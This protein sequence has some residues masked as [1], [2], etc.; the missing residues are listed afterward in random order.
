LRFG[1][2]ILEA[3]KCA[4][5]PGFP[6][7]CR[8]SGEE[9]VHD[10]LSLSDTQ[11]IAMALEKAGADALH[12]GGGSACDS[13]AWYFQH[14]SLPERAFLAD[15]MAIKMTVS[16]PVIAV[17]RLGTPEKVKEALNAFGLDFVAL[18]RPLIADPDFPMK[19]QSGNS[20]DICRCGAC[21]QGCL[22]MVKAGKGLSCLIN[23]TVGREG[24]IDAR[25]AT[26]PKTVTVI[27]GGPAGL[28]AAI[29][30]SSRGHHVDLYERDALGGQ[31]RLA[32]QAPHKEG[33]RIPY[34]HLLT[35]IR[36]QK[37]HIYLGRD[38][39]AA[40]VLEQHPDVVIVSTGAEP[41]IPAIHGLERIAYT[42]GH[43]VLAEQKGVGQR[44]LII[45]GGMV[46]METAEFLAQRGSEITVIE[47][48]DEIGRDMDTI[49]RALL[50]HRIQELPIKVLTNTVVI[51]FEV[52]EVIIE[53]YGRRDTLAAFDKVVFAVGTRSVDELSEPLKQSGLKVYT[54][55]DALRPRNALEAI[56]EGFE[57]GL[58]I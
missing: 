39:K 22:T 3:V 20:H 37:V 36:K 54:I 7:I 4:A 17:G 38:L 10:G 11:R 5:G 34:Q 24:E 55:G 53:T 44:V 29:I 31:F 32:C 42:T 15:A 26:K 43:K 18:G 56:H 14:S 50:L 52:R 23:P 51:S 45:G 8:L 41:I 57:V 25:W 28:E 33:M 9:Y 1:L 40:D 46:G 49:S 35:Q 30:A 21:L 27:G 12:I 58:T 16:I 13:P 47:M 2:Q 19:M 48:L 6:V